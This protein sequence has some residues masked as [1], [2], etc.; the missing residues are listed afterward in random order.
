MFQTRFFPFRLIVKALGSF[1]FL[2]V[3]F[4]T[5]RAQE[6]TTRPVLDFDGN[7]VFTKQ[8]LL[9]IANTCLDR[10]IDASH[11]YETEK[12]DFCLNNFVSYA[13]ARVPSGQAGKNSL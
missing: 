10:F 3:C 13:R 9:D 1:L 5:A 2:S 6:A 11:P 12:L 4:A 8:E 7:K